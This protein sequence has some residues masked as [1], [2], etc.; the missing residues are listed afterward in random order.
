MSEPI[1]NLDIQTP[2]TGNNRDMSALAAV[3]L[4]GTALTNHIGFLPVSRWPWGVPQEVQIRVLGFHPEPHCTF[5]LDV[6]T[7]SGC[8]HLIGKAYASDHQDVYQ[9]MERLRQVGFGSKAEFSI[10]AP[11]AWLPSLQVLLQEKVEGTSVKDVFRQGDG[12]QC[13]AAAE[14]CGRWLARFHTVAQASGRISEIERF[15]SSAERK[16]RLISG[17]GGPLARKSEQLLERLR[18]AAPSLAAMRKCA[19][20]GDYCEHQIILTKERTVVFDWD[21]Y[22]IA[23]PA[24]DIA[25][26]I[27]SLERLAM[28]YSGSVRAL[29]GV[30]DV[31]LRSYLD[32]GGYSCLAASLRFY[33]A[34]FWLKGRTKAIQTEAPGWGRRVE[35][36]LEE[37]LR[38]LQGG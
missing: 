13:A 17:R 21:L 27:V 34:V 11:I 5:E 9:V 3:A 24:R 33:K 36:M 32:A 14:R 29:D 6:R 30:A 15:L 19:G 38:S 20:H 1:H 10:P 16:C 31:F 35:I 4:D 8:R 26:F 22:D 2:S 18:Y 37:S 7:Q 28:K 23:D 25:H 12:Q